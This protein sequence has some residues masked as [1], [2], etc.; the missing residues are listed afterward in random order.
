MAE[1]GSEGNGNGNERVQAIVVKGG[2]EAAVE[3]LG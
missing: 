2:E 3:V 1:V